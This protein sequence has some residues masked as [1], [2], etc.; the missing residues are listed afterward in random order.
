MKLS[1]II[2]QIPEIIHLYFENFSESGLLIIKKSGEIVDCNSG[3]TKMLGLAKKPLGHNIKEFISNGS[4]KLKIPNDSFTKISLLFRNDRKCELFTKGYIF[5]LNDNLEEY[6]LII[7]DQHRLTY[8]ELV[9]K[10]S[11]LNDEVVDLSRQLKKKNSQLKEAINTVKRIMNTDHL[12]G[13]LNRRAFEKSLK[14]EISFAIRHKMPLSIIMIDIDHFKKINDTYGHETGDLVLKRFAI[15]IQKSLREEDIL[16][17]FGGEEFILALPN[18][19]SEHALD[20]SERIR[21]KIEQKK[22]R[23]IRGNITASFGITEFSPSDDI[24]SLLKRADDAL[25][26]AKRNG[27]NRC[28]IKK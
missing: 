9:A 24:R 25:Y 6:Y 13:I 26:E 2:I 27:R 23:Y 5:K 3:F 12:T 14:R 19:N 15:T 20:A 10:L 11:K 17:R 1:E 4:L 21:Q 22:I 8:N 28:E 18:T 16:G 7:F